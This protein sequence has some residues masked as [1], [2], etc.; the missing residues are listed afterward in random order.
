VLRRV[1]EAT[2]GTR[3]EARVPRGHRRHR[4]RADEAG[5]VTAETV[6]VLPVLVTFTLGLAWL[7]ALAAAHVRVV[8]AARET[9]RAVARDEDR[10]AAVQLGRR[11]APDGSRIVVGATG[12]T[13]VVR[14]RA[15]VRGPGGL[16]DFLPGVRVGAEAVAAKEP[17]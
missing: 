15:E 5:S 16:F 17:R 2:L 11:V 9:A 7:L 13:V 4:T 6:M 8:D 3:G 10:S 1:Q 12:D 14:V